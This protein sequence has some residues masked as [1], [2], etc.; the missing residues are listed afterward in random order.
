MKVLT[1]CLLGLAGVAVALPLGTFG[2]LYWQAKSAPKPPLLENIPFSAAVFARDGEMLSID[3]AEDGQF[4]LAAKR[5]ALPQAVIDATLRY[6]DRYF[7]SHPGVNP[8]SLVK[9]AWNTALGDRSI[10]ASTITMQL[11]RRLLDLDTHTPAGKW[12]QIKA[13]LRYEAHYGK[14]EILTAYLSVVPYGGNIE[15]IEAAAELYF[16]KSA[17][18]LSVNEAIALS[19]VP[20]NPVKRNPVGGIDFESA[21][22]RAGK[23]ALESGAV[24]KRIAPVLEAPLTVEKHIPFEAPHFTRRVKNLEPDAPV[25]HTGLSLP[26]N[27]AIETILKESVERTRAVGIGNAAAVAVDARTMEVVGYVGSAD[28][29]SSKIAGE[30]DGIAAARSPGS[31]LKPFIYGLAIDQG[32]IHS[33]S[34]LMDKPSNYAGYEPLN[35]D[36]RYQGPV[37]ATTALNRSRNIPA[38]DLEKQL[39]PDLYDFLKAVDVPLKHPKDWYGLSIVLGSAE[40]PMEKLAAAYATLLSQGVYSDLQWT[41]ETQRALKPIL[42]PEAA[43]IVREML[44]DGGERVTVNGVSLPLAWKTGTSNGYRDAW[45]L[46]F[47]GPYVIGVWT[48]N[49]SGRAS[50]RLRGA[51]VALPLWKTVAMRTLTEPTLSV[52]EDEARENPIWDTLPSGVSEQAVC[53]R[54]GDLAVDTFGRVL[55]E[56]TVKAWFI[57]GKSPVKPTGLLK[58]IRVDPTT[59]FRTCPAF[60]GETVIK[61]VE[62]WPEAWTKTLKENGIRPEPLPPYHPVCRTGDVMP[63]GSIVIRSPKP[64]RVWLAD[65]TTH[66]ANVTLRAKTS[67]SSTK[68]TDKN[69]YWFSEGEWIATTESG[70]SA[71]WVTGPGVKT[72]TVT[73]SAGR[74]A[75]TT[76]TVKR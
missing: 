4:R 14:D 38:I 31:T 6:E 43:A 52:K 5:A 64:N 74:T 40:V 16:G 18:D 25:I 46:G 42:S 71:V 30:V 39:K 58:E 20:Q 67:R 13:A 35:E 9:A 34:I 49:F 56:D 8:V 26:L 73:D 33:R 10:G 66:L 75:E 12:E 76:V 59:G 50:E 23:N 62:N 51:E 15:G 17:A 27:K 48:G 1:K 24:T 72:L 37:D 63:E 32:L 3:T 2:V 44:K 57:P 53:R 41:A 45:T 70:K 7:Y 19:V 29:F 68:N 21:R 55:C 28:F 60:R 11:A 65:P 22:Q 47:A 69:L 54:T 61:F 36:Q